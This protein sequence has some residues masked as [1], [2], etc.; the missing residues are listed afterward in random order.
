MEE[1]LE[2]MRKNQVWDLVDLPLNRKPIENKWF[3]KIKWKT[4][5]SIENYK[6]LLVAKGYIYL[7][8][9]YRLWGHFLSST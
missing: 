1:E 4:N 6:A 9:G 7:I 2:S 8:R 3:L 5:E